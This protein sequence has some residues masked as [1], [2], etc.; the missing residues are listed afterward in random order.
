MKD[1]KKFQESKNYEL[2]SPH[3]RKSE[4]ILRV[5]TPPDRRTIEFNFGSIWGIPDGAVPFDSER[6]NDDYKSSQRPCVVVS[7]PI[8]IN[9]NYDAIFAPGTTK[10][11]NINDNKMPILFTSHEEEKLN[12]DTYFLLYYKFTISPQINK[13]WFCNLSP[14][15]KNKLKLLMEMSN[16]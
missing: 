12:L 16:G 15:A 3:K 6:K 1:K 10:W 11:H 9:S 8:D 5:Y 13:N 2:K 14:T 7:K 4:K